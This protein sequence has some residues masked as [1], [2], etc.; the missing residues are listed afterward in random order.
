MKPTNL[1]SANPAFGKGLRDAPAAPI[2]ELSFNLGL[3]LS[4]LESFLQIRLHSFTEATR[5]SVAR[6][7]WIKEFRL[8]GAALRLCSDLALKLGE[9]IRKKD[10]SEAEEID[11]FRD[12]GSTDAAEFGFDEIAALAAALKEL[13]LL[14]EALLRAAPLK[15]TE[16]TAWCDIVSDRLAQ[17]NAVRKLVEN[18][19]REGERFLPAP[20]LDLLENSSLAPADETDL[21]L[22]LPH[23]TKI[24]KWLEV[25]GQMMESDQP[26]KLVVLLFARIQEQTQAMISYINRRLRRFSGEDEPIYAVL[27]CAVYAASIEARKVYNFELGGLAE[28]RQP[29]LIRAKTETSYALLNDCFQLILVQFAQFIEPDFE[30]TRLFPNFKTKLEQSLTLRGDLW[31]IQQLVQK[32]EH[33]SE[34]ALLEDLSGKLNDF[35]KTSLR[36][37]MYKDCET[38]ERFAEEVLRTRSKKDLVPILHRFGAYLETLFGQVNMRTVLSNHPFDYPK[39]GN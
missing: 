16:W 14:N 11:L 32:A 2:R 4:G 26:L 36:Y 9:A 34:N 35:L 29:V 27:D 20:L 15:L 22:V 31:L 30:P 18:A 7:D 17:D 13:I 37:L 1:D 12:A 8:T 19:E 10:F 25:I 39:D 33:N 28:I 5:A 21:R 24:L 3:W 23:F 6:R 38:F